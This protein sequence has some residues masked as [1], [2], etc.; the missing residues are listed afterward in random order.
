M[1]ATMNPP[2]KDRNMILEQMDRAKNDAAI[3]RKIRK[4]W[5]A[6]GEDDCWWVVHG[7]PV[8]PLAR[9]NSEPVLTRT[10]T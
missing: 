9:Y 7:T 6:F 2:G 1:M 5:L 10:H 3:M 4:G 8:P